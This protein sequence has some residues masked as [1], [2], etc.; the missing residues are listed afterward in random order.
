MDSN[1][2]KKEW[3]AHVRNGTAPDNIAYRIVYLKQK[4]LVFC[5][6]YKLA[7]DR[8]YESY[9]A[10]LYDNGTL[11]AIIDLDDIRYITSI[12]KGY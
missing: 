9:V 5:T 3:N 6:D 12:L 4:S 8:L 11:V 10:K 1:E 7:F 2:F